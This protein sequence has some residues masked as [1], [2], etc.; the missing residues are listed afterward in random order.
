M[1]ETKLVGGKILEM[2]TKYRRE[3]ENKLK[4]M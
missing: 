1:K 3:T 2:I 4:E